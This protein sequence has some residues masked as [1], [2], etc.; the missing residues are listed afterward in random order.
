MNNQPTNVNNL[1]DSNIEVEVLEYLKARQLFNLR[2]VSAEQATKFAIENFIVR[3]GES[4]D[5][6]T[7]YD[8]VMDLR[9]GDYAAVDAAL[10][11]L[12]DEMKEKKTA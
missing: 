10:L 11:S 1:P 5:M 9:L 4:T 12:L 7:F 3:I 6:D 8:T 2:S